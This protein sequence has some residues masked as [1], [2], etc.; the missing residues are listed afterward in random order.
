ML[1][2]QRIPQAYMY[3]GQE[4]LTILVATPTPWARRKYEHQ[5]SQGLT[6]CPLRTLFV[7]RS[8]L[9]CTFPNF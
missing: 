2:T 8:T 4:V 3:R 1:I 5:R 7:I 6:L 9:G